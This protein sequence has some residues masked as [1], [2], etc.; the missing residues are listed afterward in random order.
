MSPTGYQYD[1]AIYSKKLSSDFVSSQELIRPVIEHLCGRYKTVIIAPKSSPP[2]EFYKG[3]CSK[4]I[5]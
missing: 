4:T 5:N 2:D 1:I 3:I